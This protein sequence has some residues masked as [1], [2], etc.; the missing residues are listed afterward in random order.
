[1]YSRAAAAGVLGGLG[2]EQGSDSERG[3]RPR[4]PPARAAALGAAV[5]AS[6]AGAGLAG[7]V[8][9]RV[10]AAASGHQARRPA[11]SGPPLR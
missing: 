2:S 5:G 1:M 3:V 9:G 7:F 8:Q 4:L 6:Q 11:L 10:R